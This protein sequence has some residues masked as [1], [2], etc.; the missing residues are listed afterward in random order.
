MR[1]KCSPKGKKG[2][3]D[4]KKDREPTRGWGENPHVRVSGSKYLTFKALD[5]SSY[6]PSRMQEL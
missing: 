1:G 3:T 6:L 5:S 4:K 2:T